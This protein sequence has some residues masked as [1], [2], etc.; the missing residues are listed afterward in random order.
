MNTAKRQTTN[1]HSKCQTGL[2]N[3]D[4]PNPRDESPID[5]S[6]SSK[7][8]HQIVGAAETPRIHPTKQQVKTPTSSR[9]LAL[10]SSRAPRL[11]QRPARHSIQGLG[12]QF[13]IKSRHSS[14]PHKQS[15]RQLL[16][17]ASSLGSKLAYC[18]SQ[19]AIQPAETKRPQ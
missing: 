15:I 11:E 18:S 12:M 9:R 1:L 2:S 7:Q 3:L 6:G 14:P 5:Q 8:W 17:E 10:A 19:K 13:A 4:R 16:P